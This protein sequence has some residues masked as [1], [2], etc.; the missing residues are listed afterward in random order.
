MKRR[1]TIRI[2]RRLHFLTYEEI[3]SDETS[4]YDEDQLKKQKKYWKMELMK[5]P[6]IPL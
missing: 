4:I 1:L 6:Q 5:M 2:W 3:L